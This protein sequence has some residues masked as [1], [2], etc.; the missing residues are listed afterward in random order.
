MA[1]SDLT[2][3]ASSTVNAAALDVAQLNFD[4]ASTAASVSSLNT[5]TKSLQQSVRNDETKFKVNAA[6]S[7]KEI[8]AQIKM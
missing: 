1:T 4:A 3:G 6:N 2:T 7:M 8:G 5:A